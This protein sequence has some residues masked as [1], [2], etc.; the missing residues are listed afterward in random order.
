M[1]SPICSDVFETHNGTRSVDDLR[2]KQRIYYVCD[3]AA[4]ESEYVHQAADHVKRLRAA[5]IAA[6]LVRTPEYVATG[7][8]DMQ[9][10][11]ATIAFS[12]FTRS[13]RPDKDYLVVPG[14][15][16]ERIAE[17]PGRKVIYVT[18]TLE[19]FAPFKDEV[20]NR[21]PFASDDVKAIFTPSHLISRHLTATFPHVRAVTL[22]PRIDRNMF[23]PQPMRKK[24]PQVAVPKAEIDYI[25]P[26]YHMVMARLNNG[27][28]RAAFDWVLIEGTDR[29]VSR[30]LRDSVLVPFLVSGGRYSSLPAKAIACGCVLISFSGS[31]SS[32]GVPEEWQCRHGDL[33]WAVIRVEEVM[34]AFYQDQDDLGAYAE[35]VVNRQTEQPALDVVEVWRELAE[36]M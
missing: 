35:T 17:Y 14:T 19:A 16:G 4:P 22:R 27:L 7:G 5:D 1:P 8:S 23:Y 3:G 31:A 33:C 36:A 32:E 26:L 2:R 12:D 18:S 24:K 34:R 30:I 20:P 13:Y 28:S 9:G 15:A 11:G 10:E 25:L 6:A 29:D 21:Y